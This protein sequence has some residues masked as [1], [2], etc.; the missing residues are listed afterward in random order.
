MGAFKDAV[1]Q[2]RDNGG[3][4]IPDVGAVRRQQ[5]K[6]GYGLSLEQSLGKDVGGFFRGNWSDG[7]TETYAFTEI[8][9]QLAIGFLAQGRSWGR[10]LDTFGLAYARNELSPE[11]QQYLQ[12]GGLGAFIGDGR[13]TYAPEQVIETFYSF[14]LFPNTS[15]TLDYQ[16]IMNP[17]Y[18]S[19]RG[20]VN[21]WALRL[22]TEL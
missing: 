2:W 14:N 1:N 18:N 10:D 9:R 8:E 4:G 20:P 7:Q 11:H 16:F 12:T 19:D 5:A 6:W 21:F 17:A 15:L 13:L 22:H 3:V